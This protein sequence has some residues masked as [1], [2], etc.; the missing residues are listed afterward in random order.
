MAQ[1]V[2][3][4]NSHDKNNVKND[5][6]LLNQCGEIFEYRITDELFFQVKGHFNSNQ[7]GIN[8]KRSVITNRIPFVQKLL[9][10]IS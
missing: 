3:V 4:Y 8:K 7:H 10:L 9:E 1:I 5:Q 6:L 2:P